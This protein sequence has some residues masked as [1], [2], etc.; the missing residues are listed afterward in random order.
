[1]CGPTFYK[2]LAPN[3]A[4]TGAPNGENQHTFFTRSPEELFTLQKLFRVSQFFP[5]G[6]SNRG[7][8]QIHRLQF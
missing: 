4:K 1:M 3:G 8:L 6:F 7:I 5:V 2:Y